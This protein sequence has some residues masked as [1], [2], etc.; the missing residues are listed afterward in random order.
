MK[1]KI[2]KKQNSLTG[3]HLIGKIYTKDIYSLRSLSKTK[4]GIS[5]LIKKYYLKELGSFYYKFTKQ[6][7]FTGIVSLVESH[8]AIHTWPE[9]NCLTLDVYLCNYSRDNSRVCR[10]IFDEICK[11]FKPS[12]IIKRIINR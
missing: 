1:N 8:V 3:L 2:T 7:G 5:L 6:G 9:F 10:K 12:R 11:I 4:R